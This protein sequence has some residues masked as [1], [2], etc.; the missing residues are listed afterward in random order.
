[1]VM[2]F[3]FLIESWYKSTFKNVWKDIE[4][5]YSLVSQKSVDAYLFYGKIRLCLP[6]NV[7][8]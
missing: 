7:E 5:N 6:R 2:F 1:M 8:V 3:V 4:K